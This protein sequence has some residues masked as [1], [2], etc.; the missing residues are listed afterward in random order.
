MQV[1]Y[2]SSY[3]VQRE[4]RPA[5]FRPPRRK[6]ALSTAWVTLSLSSGTGT[7]VPRV[8]WMWRALSRTTSITTSFLGLSHPKNRTAL[9]RLA[10]WP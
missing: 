9:T 3:E 10:G 7:C 8:R 1:R 5:A 2:V 4:L 6:I